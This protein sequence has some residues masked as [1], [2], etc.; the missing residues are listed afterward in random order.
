MVKAQGSGSAVD[1]LV[2]SQHNRTLKGGEK[3]WTRVSASQ[4]LGEL[5]FAMPS[6]QGRKAREVVQQVWAQTVALPDG[7]KGQLQASCIVAREMEPPEGEKPIEWHL[8][9]YSGDRDR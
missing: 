9:A 5:R 1:W 8:L 2:R 7:A 4:A 6:R 3:L